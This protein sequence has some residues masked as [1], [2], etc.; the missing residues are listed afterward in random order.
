LKKRRGVETINFKNKKIKTAIF[1]FIGVSIIGGMIYK[2]GLNDVYTNLKKIDPYYFIFGFILSLVTILIKMLR[3]STLFNDVKPRDAWK[4]YLI[5]QAVNQIAPTGSGELTRAYVGKREFDVPVANVLA[6]AAVERI[7][8][9]TFLLG[10]AALLVSIFMEDSLFYY[11]NVLL[12][13]C[14]LLG[15]GY[16][17]IVR[18]EIFEK[19]SIK[20]ENLFKKKDAWLNKFFKKTAKT[21]RKIKCSLVLF[22]ENKKVIYKTIFFT[23]IS[24]IIYGLGFYALI[25][26]M[27]KDIGKFGFISSIVVVAASEIIGSFSFLP[28]GLGAKEATITVFLDLVYSIPA[29]IGLALSL[30]WRFITYFQIGG[31]TLI[32]LISISN[33][34]LEVNN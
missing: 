15:I 11:Y 21:L 17:S 23:V 1:L 18:P 10:M 28:G 26:G 3:W 29:D 34:N 24:W 30:V 13:S 33:K 20:L 2:I 9:T 4:I 31:G 16:Y 12:L 25:L 6:P 27:D 32:S 14:C 7:S 5:G 19:I 8:D 22:K